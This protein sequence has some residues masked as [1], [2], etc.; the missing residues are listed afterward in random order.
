MLF[1]SK[2]DFAIEAM[3]EPG[4]IPP[5]SVWGRMRIWCEGT[6][7]GDYSEKHCGLPSGH[8]EEL[9]R[10]LPT[11]WHQ[12]FEG[13][14]DADIFRYLDAMIYSYRDGKEVDDDSSLMPR[15]VDGDKL[16]RFIFLTN[17]EEMFDQE[18]KAFVLCPDGKMVRVIVQSVDQLT[19]RSLT[20]SAIAV[21]MACESFL[22]WFREESVRLSVSN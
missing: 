20:A 10:D 5:T 16:G 7:L 4:L 11:L 1:G 3:V 19:Y 17:W 13:L 6:P 22:S 14:D 8:I 21:K 9:A 18:G 15:A 12:D 2:G